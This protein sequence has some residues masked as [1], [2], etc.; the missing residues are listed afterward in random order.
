MLTA[1]QYERLPKLAREIVD[2][3]R[4]TADAVGAP[5]VKIGLAWALREQQARRCSLTERA[6]NTWG[7]KA[8]EG[9][10]R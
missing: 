9:T 4:E 6:A 10:R 1:D 2:M 3:D 7:S 5:V 8:K